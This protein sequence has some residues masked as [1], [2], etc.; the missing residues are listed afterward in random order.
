ML[1]INCIVALCCI[2]QW[3]AGPLSSSADHYRNTQRNQTLMDITQ[4]NS[5]EQSA[6]LVSDAHF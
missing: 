6:I 1:G 4:N 2:Q 3:F 5:H